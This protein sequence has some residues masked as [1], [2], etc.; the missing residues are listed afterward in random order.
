MTELEQEVEEV[1]RDFRRAERR[2]EAMKEIGRALGSSLHLDDLL[3]ELVKRTTDLLEA[4][5]STL[6][7]LDPETEQLWS[8]VLEGQEHREI[9]MPV[10]AGIAGW[11]ASTGKP[12]LIPDAYEDDRFNHDFDK[13]SGYRTRDILTWP[14][15]RPQEGSTLGVIQVLN[16]REGRFNGDDERLIEAIASEI[17]VALEV[18]ALYREA[19]ERTEALERARGE[20]ALLFE[21]ERAISQSSDLAA[22]LGTILDTAVVTM[23]ARS[24][25]LHVLAEGGMRLE[26][27][28][29]RGV[30]AASVLKAGADLSQGVPGAV[31]KTNEPVCF[32]G[33]EGMK[34]GRIKIRSILAVPIRNRYEGVIGALELLNTKK[35]TDSFGDEDVRTLTL[36]AAQAGRAIVAERRRRERAQQDRLS[37]IGQM[38]SGVIHDFRTPMTLIS[39]YTQ[40][41]AGVEDASSRTKYAELVDRQISLLTSMTKELLAFARGERSLLIRKVQMP[42]FMEEMKD[43]LTAEL[44]GS[45]VELAVQVEY[46]GPARF[47]ESKLR[48]VFHNIARNAREALPDGGHFWVSVAQEG[49]ELVFQFED[50]GP[51]IPEDLEHRLFEPFAS[52][53]K[54]GGTGLG[55][56][57][58]K[59]ILEEHGGRIEHQRPSRGGTRFVLQLPLDP[60]T[61]S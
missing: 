34:R 58:V 46:R 26:T 39:G 3:D 24:G 42:R 32:N 48:R 17:G 30:G 44:D 1:R 23:G 5:R 25:A 27:L 50:D 20:L 54:V 52:S 28:A 36:V 11:V 19:V 53:G 41:M 57:M 40:I 21:T 22:M 9:R 12:L 43:Y 35:R 29:A 10:G 13:R 7:L 33:I 18:S 38:L 6:F 55:L 60:K 31:V 16:K 51:G 2:V 15:R 56:T 8:K 14:V 59:Q 47:D 4:D 45:G 37:A 49:E 61:E